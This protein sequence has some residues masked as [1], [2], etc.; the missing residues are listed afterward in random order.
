MTDYLEKLGRIGRITDW[1][2]RQTVDALQ[3][4][5]VMGEVTWAQQF[6]W[7][8][9]KASARTLP[10]HHPTIARETAPA[11]VRG[12]EAHQQTGGA[13]L[14]RVRDTHPALLDALRVEIRRRGYS[15]RTEQTYESWVA[16]YLA[17]VGKAD[18]GG[19]GG[20]EVKAFLQHL[21]VERLVTAST[22]NQARNALVFFAQ[23]VLQQP[24]GD[25]DGSPWC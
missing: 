25:L 3:H 12:N 17:F 19:V 18:P 11:T 20:A 24:L 8:Y 14:A 7:A 16:R 5:C 22:Q 9:W 15:I 23:H 6:D 10:V 13:S 4:L 21:A 2:Y 1:Q